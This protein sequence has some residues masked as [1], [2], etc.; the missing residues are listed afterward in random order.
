[1]VSGFLVEELPIWDCGDFGFSTRTAR[2]A[3]IASCLPEH[4]AYHHSKKDPG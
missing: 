4:A 2:P 1:M 3:S